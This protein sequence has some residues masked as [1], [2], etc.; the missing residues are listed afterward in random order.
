MRGFKRAGIQ[1][2][3]IDDTSTPATRK[4]VTDA[5]KRGLQR[6]VPV[7][8]RRE[9]GTAEREANESVFEETGE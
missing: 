7:D 1:P 5:E 6:K 2:F 9:D 4:A 3:L 8:L